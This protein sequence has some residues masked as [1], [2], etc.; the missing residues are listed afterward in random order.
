MSSPSPSNFSGLRY[1]RL[2]R[3]GRTTTCLEGIGDSLTLCGYDT[4]GDDLV[5]DVLPEE[6]RGHHRVTCEDCQQIMALV[7][8]HRRRRPNDKSS[9]TRSDGAAQTH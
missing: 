4:S 8:A 2:V 5:H 3:E 7:D 1:Y 6:L 9:Q